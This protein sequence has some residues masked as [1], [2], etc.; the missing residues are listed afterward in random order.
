MPN[1]PGYEV[2]AT[3]LDANLKAIREAG[4]LDTVLARLSPELKAAAQSP[5]GQSWWPGTVNEGLIAALCAA[6]GERAV[7]EVGFLSVQRS[8]GPLVMPFLKVLLAVTGADPATIFSKLGQ[9]SS[10]STRGVTIDWKLGT[11]QQGDLTIVYPSA[12]DPSVKPLW[13]GGLR[14]GLTMLKRQGRVD[15]R[16]VDARTLRYQISWD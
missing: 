1:A 11:G 9:F 15:D 14:C 13:R 3:Y 2:S 6:H 5:Y 4:L 10:S 7:E 12:V 16:H 8:V